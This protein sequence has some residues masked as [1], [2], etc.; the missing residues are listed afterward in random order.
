M[1]IFKIRGS[2]IFKSGEIWDGTNS[3]N[4]AIAATRNANLTGVA[5]TSWWTR[6]NNDKLIGE[7]FRIPFLCEQDA[8]NICEKQDHK[9]ANG[10]VSIVPTSWFKYAQLYIIN[11]IVH[12]FKSSIAYR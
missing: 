3:I 5:I 8:S 11:V 6:T 12:A 1:P 2:A 10:Y 9:N 7:A 4:D